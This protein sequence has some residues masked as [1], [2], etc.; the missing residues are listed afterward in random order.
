MSQIT[1]E[2]LSHLLLE[3]LNETE[4]EHTKDM[5]ET[6]HNAFTQ[7]ANDFVDT[8]GKK[9]QP[10]DLK[11]H[12]KIYPLAQILISI[13]RYYEINKETEIVRDIVLDLL[14]TLETPKNNATVH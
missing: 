2:A 4:T 13:V 3:L 1:Q 7:G 9:L 14:D 10:D 8:S 5:L 6:A 12:L 11:S